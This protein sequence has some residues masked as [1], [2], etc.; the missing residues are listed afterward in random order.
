M[1]HPTR[2]VTEEAHHRHSIVIIWPAEL[3]LYVRREKTQS[4]NHLCNCGVVEES[5]HPRVM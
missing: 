3:Y 4:G 2:A 5:E 1:V